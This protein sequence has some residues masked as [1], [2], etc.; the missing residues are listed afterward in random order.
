[1]DLA[2]ASVNNGLI[3]TAGNYLVSE[4]KMLATLLAG[5]EPLTDLHAL[6]DFCTKAGAPLCGAGVP[7]TYTVGSGTGSLVPVKDAGYF[8]DWF[9]RK[10][11]PAEVVYLDSKPYTVVGVD[12]EASRLR[13]DQPAEWRDQMPV[14]WLRSQADIGLHWRPTAGEP[15]PP[16]PPQPEPTTE[17][18]RL[19]LEFTA[20]SQQ[21]ELLRQLLQSVRTVV[22]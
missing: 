5:A 22:Q 11:L 18:V 16:E 21:V 6:E 9:G 15:L 8:T 3:E 19:V 12:L 7:L 20:S 10:E 17:T 1:M 13:L 4:R 2:L 14:Y